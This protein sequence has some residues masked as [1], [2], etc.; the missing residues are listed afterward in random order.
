MAVSAQ[1]FGLICE[2]TLPALSGIDSD[3]DPCVTQTGND[4]G[5]IMRV[6]SQMSQ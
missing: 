3:I 5:F 2:H 4:C 1:K 6:L